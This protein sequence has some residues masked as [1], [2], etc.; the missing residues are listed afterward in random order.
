MENTGKIRVLVLDENPVLV[1]GLNFL[2]NST[3]QLAALAL[4]NR[5]QRLQDA[6]KRLEPDVIVA[7]P[8]HLDRTLEDC[9]M[10]LQDLRARAKLIAYCD[11]RDSL[12]GESYVTR[13]YS[14]VVTKSV[15]S[16]RLL[17]AIKSVHAGDVVID[18][19]VLAISDPPPNALATGS[20]KL[21]MK[22]E[23][24]LRHVALGKA[25]KEIAADIQ[26]SAKTVETYKYRATKKLDLRT[27]SD[28]VSYAMSVGW[29]QH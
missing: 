27:R 21:S 2:V 28:I 13:G 16:P 15:A 9:E 29:L 14:G 6:V 25:M 8:V 18:E 5:D 3:R 10:Q 20:R 22:E 1:D 24:V 7:D 12:P 11:I 19:A 17:R 23:F 26:L 4:T